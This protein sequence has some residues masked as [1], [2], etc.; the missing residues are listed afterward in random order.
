MPTAAL[1]G[2]ITRRVTPALSKRVALGDAPYWNPNAPSGRRTKRN[3]QHC[4]HIAIPP[5][6]GPK[7]FSLGNAPGTFFVVL[8]LLQQRQS[9]DRSVEHIKASPG[10]AFLR[11]SRHYHGVATQDHSLKPNTKLRPL[12]LFLI[13][14][15]NELFAANKVEEDDE[16]RC[17]VLRTTSQ[18]PSFP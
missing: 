3:R 10:W 18:S 9:R 14:L 8:R 17:C 7:H 13:P 2:F 5:R 15:L 1:C 11:S 4:R 6:M 16:S 12:L